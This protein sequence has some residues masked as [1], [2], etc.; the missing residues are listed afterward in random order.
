MTTSRWV[1]GTNRTITP[2]AV[3][4]WTDDQDPCTGRRPWPASDH[5]VALREDKADSA[6][7]HH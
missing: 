3:P 4:Q 6:K 1:A 2:S 7:A 5:P